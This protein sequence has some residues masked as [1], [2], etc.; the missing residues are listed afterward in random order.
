MIGIDAVDVERL[1]DVMARTHGA[2][3]RLFTPRERTYCQSRVDPVV[4][5]AGTLAVKEAV[6]KAASLGP[7]VAWGRRIEVRRNE[8]GAPQVELLG[9]P[10]VRIDV[11]ISHDGPV[12]VAVAVAR[13]SGPLPSD[14]ERA[15]RRATA[16]PRPNDQLLRYLGMSQP[17][18][19]GSRGHLQNASR[20]VQGTD[21]P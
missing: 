9:V 19:N 1:R 13:N 10:H 18:S 12:A 20:S 16:A 4:H 2:E 17:H 8:S 21:F 5:Y 15:D 3:E 6:I 11:S 14:D 7:L